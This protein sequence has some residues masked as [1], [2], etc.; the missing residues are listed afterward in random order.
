VGSGVKTGGWGGPW[1]ALERPK[2]PKVEDR[3]LYWSEP[4]HMR[5]DRCEYWL[6]QF[7]RGWRPNGRILGM[8]YDSDAQWFG[9]YLW[10]YL[11]VLSPRL[12]ELRRQTVV[13]EG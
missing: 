3:Y 1:V 8:G 7:E 4:P 13:P 9:V 5:S 11:N 6:R 10:E 2:P 12:D